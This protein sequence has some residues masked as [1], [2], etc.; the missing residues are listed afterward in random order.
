MKYLA[1]YWTHKLK[2][3]VD[4]ADHDLFFYPNYVLMN[5]I[6]RIII[7][8]LYALL[9]III[10]IIANPFL[11]ACAYMYNYVCILHWHMLNH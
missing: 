5:A 1:G 4:P 9:H 6:H 3:P 10:I 7:I 2:F 8:C 11:D